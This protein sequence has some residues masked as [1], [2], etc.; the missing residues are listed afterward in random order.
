MFQRAL[1]GN[2]KVEVEVMC[3]RALGGYHTLVLRT[4]SNLGSLYADQGKLEEAGLIYQRAPVEYEKARGPD[5][6]LT[7][8]TIN[9]LSHL[10]ANQ[11]KPAEA[12]AMYQRAEDGTSMVVKL[13]I[14]D[15]R[16]Q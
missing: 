9:N 6:T 15:S 11:G 16:L 12:E 5:H 2:E 10:Y 7:L 1:P 13:S 3:Q 4:V 8:R 14:W